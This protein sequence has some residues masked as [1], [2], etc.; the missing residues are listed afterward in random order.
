MKKKIILYISLF[1]ILCLTGVYASRFM[2]PQL[3]E[4]QGKYFLYDSIETLQKDSQFIVE[5]QVIEKKNSVITYTEDKCPYSGH[6]PVTVKVL[7]SLPGDSMLEN[8]EITIHEYYYNYITP[9]GSY[10]MTEEGYIPM[11]IN[12]KYLLFLAEDKDGGFFTIGPGFQGK[13][14][15]TE[16][17]MI[18]N[19]D[20]A[21]KEDLEIGEGADINHYRKLYREVKKFKETYDGK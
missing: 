14:V 6:T 3:V 5:V 17:G 10:L 9:I 18:D 13:Y 11:K 4:A 12:G 8:K 20:S 16:E 21:T 2:F 19:I 15:V 7:K 1:C